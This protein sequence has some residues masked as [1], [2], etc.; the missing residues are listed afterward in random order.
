MKKKYNFNF[1]HYSKLSKGIAKSKSFNKSSSQKVAALSVIALPCLV[2]PTQ[3]DAQIIRDNTF[4]GA[5]FSSS[6]GGFGTS[7]MFIKVDDGFSGGGQH[8]GL[9]A[10]A[11][12]ADFSIRIDGG[13]MKAVRLNANNKMVTAGGSGTL[14]V[15][16]S[17][18]AINTGNVQNGYGAGN[19]EFFFTFF[20][21][22]GGNFATG[23]NT[24]K[25]GYV[26]FRFR[27]GSDNHFG[28]IKVGVIDEAATHA[29]RR[30]RLIEIGYEQTANTP[31]NAIVPVELID[32]KA[33]T[34]DAQVSLS[35]KTAS[36]INNAGFEVQRSTDGRNFQNLTFVEGKGTS[37]EKNKYHFDDKTVR[38]RQL[39]YYRLRQIDFDGNFEF[40]KVLTAK[41][42]GEGI[43]GVFSPNPSKV[44]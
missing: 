15:L 24:E 42:E 19:N 13:S 16:T 26:G 36:E 34:S 5:S 17:N 20:N 8:S 35:W 14:A 38:S 4:T 2:M 22:T 3:I 29:N 40:S 43:S 23:A 27:I 7:P 10:G 31:I 12:S 6:G 1:E 39:Y 11:G 30:F 37:F 41:L 33:K 21:G 44:N 18:A 25:I 28:F 9:A 32:F